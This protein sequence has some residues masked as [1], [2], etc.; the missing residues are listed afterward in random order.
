MRSKSSKINPTLSL[1]YNTTF[2]LSKFAEL[3][4][5]K[6]GSLIVIF[7]L[8]CSKKSLK[9]FLS[10]IPN[11]NPITGSSSVFELLNT[12]RVGFDASCKPDFNGF[13]ITFSIISF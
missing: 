13:S 7:L 5:S 9:L 3:N 4:P 2:S 8:I 10:E 11:I 12:K 1:K 6:S